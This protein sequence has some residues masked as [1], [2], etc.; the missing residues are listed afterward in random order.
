MSVNIVFLT[1]SQSPDVGLLPDTRL[2]TAAEIERLSQP[3][4]RD[5]VA[6]FKDL[7]GIVP[8]GHTFQ[9]VACIPVERMGAEGM[10]WTRPYSQ[11]RIDVSAGDLLFIN[12]PTIWLTWTRFI[13]TAQ[14]GTPPEPHSIRLTA[15]DL[16]RVYTRYADE[17]AQ[18]HEQLRIEEVARSLYGMIREAVK[19]QVGALDRRTT[20]M[21]ADLQVIEQDRADLLFFMDPYT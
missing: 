20:N 17:L 6:A 8:K 13:P 12:S 15:P 5:V 11:Q 2:A 4:E 1:R 18:M 14:P 21:R 3:F 9:V 10:K 7:Q 16:T 19:K